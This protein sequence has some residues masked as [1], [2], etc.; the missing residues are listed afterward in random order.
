MKQGRAVRDKAR[1][2]VVPPRC[3]FMILSSMP[4]S[5]FKLRA[6]ELIAF[7]IS[8]ATRCWSTGGCSTKSC[9][10]P[11]LNGALYLDAVYTRHEWFAWR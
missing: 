4:T 11:L 8:R 10:N 5:A 1:T 3:S 2:M 9:T 7:L 6:L